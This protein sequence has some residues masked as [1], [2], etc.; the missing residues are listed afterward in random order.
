MNQEPKF[1]LYSGAQCASDRPELAPIAGQRVAVI[2]RFQDSEGRWNYTVY[3]SLH[4]TS[5]AYT[6]FETDLV[7]VAPIPFTPD[8]EHM[9]NIVA[10]TAKLRYSVIHGGLRRLLQQRGIDPMKC[11][12]ISCDQG[13]DVNITL[14]LPDG[15][16]VNTDYRQDPQTRQAT[17]F[18]A[19]EVQDYPPDRMIELCREIL[20]RDD[21]SEFDETVRRYF[22]EHLA[23]ADRPL[24]P[25]NPIWHDV[26]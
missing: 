10:Q 1:G 14:V 8:S 2:G 3:D 5:A 20:S 6:C 11:F 7:P 24:P 26:D 19:W 23:A 18:E 17:R 22:E 13:F 15:T 21:T 4:K 25:E 9:T 12:Q 16:V